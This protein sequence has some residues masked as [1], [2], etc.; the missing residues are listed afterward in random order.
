MLDKPL[1]ASSNRALQIVKRLFNANKAGHTGNLDPLATGMLPICLGHATK[2]SGLLLDS[3]KCY[4]ADVR[5]GQKTST[6]DAEGEVIDSS[7]PSSLDE[8]TLRSVLP[9]FEGEIEQVPPMYSALKHQGKRLYELARQGEVV[10]RPARKVIIKSLELLSFEPD[11]FL[12]NVRCSKGTYIRTLAEDIAAAAGQV[13]H[14][15]GLRRTGVLPFEA[16]AMHGLEALEATAD[17]GQVELDALLLPLSAAVPGWEQI[18]LPDQ[19]LRCLARGQALDLPSSQAAEGRSLA[20]T[21]A[22]G[23]LIAAGGLDDQGRLISRR[24]LSSRN[25]T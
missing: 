10:E 3:D 2:L 7:D 4:L 12:I 15:G 19:A 22:H 5:V 14:L 13:A 18:R 9:R 23:E 8:A 6:G 25:F 20:L 16:N 17:R 11:R 24:W 21:D 1:G